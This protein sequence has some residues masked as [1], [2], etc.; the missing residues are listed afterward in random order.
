MKD[1][2]FQV[3]H[4]DAG[5][6]ARAGEMVT[7][8]GLVPTPVFMPVGT[9]G[10]VKAMS[11]Q[12]LLDLG[13]HLILGNTYHLLLRPGPDIVAEM[14]GLHRFAG[15]P[16]SILTDSG[17]YQIFS[18][19]ALTR[20]EEEGAIFQSHL[21]GTRYELTPERSL[22]VQAALGSDIAMALDV[23]PP[24]P[25]SREQVEEAVGVTSRWAGRSRRAAG[26]DQTVFG[27]VQGGIHSDLRRRSVEE[28]GEMNF[29]G[30]AIG[31]VQV[32]ETPGQVLE[33][34]SFTADL[35][36]VERPRYLMGM[37]SPEDLLN[38][39]DMGLDM[40]DCVLPTRNGRNGTLF[41]SVG[42]ISIKRSQYARDSRAVD[43][44]CFCYTCRTFSRAYL[45]H[46]FRAGE[47]LGARLNTLHNVHFYLDL[48]RRARQAILG[49]R[50]SSFRRSTL[51]SLQGT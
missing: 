30:Y 20:I 45:R 6:R 51:E 29:P 48:M 47:I 3:V 49:D 35:L 42:R 14:G 26:A 8:H 21:D 31:G 15:W 34:A 13:S 28:L 50:Y 44:N 9:Q 17:G 19:A 38:L 37:G 27:I 2:G 39:I 33:V 11:P 4:R 1:F 32:G 23:C 10:T 41:T 24:Y 18:L 25:A 46:L 12:E 5:S 36:P 40:F 43:E 16:R 7:S 22:E